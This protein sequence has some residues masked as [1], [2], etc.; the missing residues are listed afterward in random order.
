MRVYEGLF[1]FDPSLS[2]EGLEDVL[3]KV[4]ALV[5]KRDGKICQTI[6]LGKK[7]LG[8]EVKKKRVG[9]VYM[10]DIEISPLCLREMK[11]DFKL[12]PEIFRASIFR[13]DD[14]AVVIGEPV[15]VAN[16]A[17]VVDVV[18]EA[19]ETDDSAAE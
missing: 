12:V 15:A 7:S 6:E 5:V 16:E 18:A 9:F 13:K 2:A 17:T 1:I 10:I 3:K 14:K 4:E 8:F 19:E 11:Y